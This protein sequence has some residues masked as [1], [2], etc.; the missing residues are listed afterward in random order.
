[1]HSFAFPPAYPLNLNSDVFV[2]VLHVLHL[3][4]R[5]CSLSALVPLRFYCMRG[6][7]MVPCAHFLKGEGMRW[8]S[9]LGQLAT[10]AL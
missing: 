8:G 3:M 2:I 9:K 10:L 7:E 4:R 5:M 1:M 6:L